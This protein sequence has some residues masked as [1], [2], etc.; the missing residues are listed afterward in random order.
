MTW[1]LVGSALEDLQASSPGF[2]SHLSAI[3]YGFR[4]VLF[5]LR[6]FIE[7]CLSLTTFIENCL[8]LTP[9]HATRPIAMKIVSGYQT[10]SHSVKFIMLK[11]IGA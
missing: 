2:E 7:N 10:Y 6:T 3:L 1:W 5:S 11:L 8:S 4:S 9:Y